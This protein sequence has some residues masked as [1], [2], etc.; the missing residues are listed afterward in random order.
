MCVAYSHSRA[1]EN[2]ARWERIIDRKIPDNAIPVGR[3]SQ[4]RVLYAGR[5]LVRQN[6]Y[7]FVP[8]YVCKEEPWVLA[9]YGTRARTGTQDEVLVSDKIESI[10]WESSI[11]PRFPVVGGSDEDDKY[12]IGRTR[13]T[14]G[15][16][17]RGRRLSITNLPD[18]FCLPGKVHPSHAV[19]YAP[20]GDKEY[21]FKDFETMAIKASPRS[22]FEIAA[23]T[24]K[25][26]LDDDKLISLADKQILSKPV[27]AEV[28][29]VSPH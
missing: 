21:I 25:I 19:L 20:F 9:A 28:L 24:L 4:N 17:W 27:L 1:E 2:A 23:L 10:Y 11:T 16:T 8:G 3:D 7:R 29:S 18:E 22:L 6:R 26:N 13:S 14:F 12:L 15:R 5:C